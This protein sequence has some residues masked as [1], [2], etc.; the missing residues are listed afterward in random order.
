MK[1]VV[2]AKDPA[3]AETWRRRWRIPKSTVRVVTDPAQVSDM[4]VGNNYY[5]Q[6]PGGRDDV[7]V[8]VRGRWKH[9]GRVDPEN[10]GVLR[11][12]VAKTR[13]ARLAIRLGWS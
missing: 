4:Q 3:E 7:V 10:G 12:F 2:I 5:V 11:A 1:L 6:L 9:T 13:R 8:A